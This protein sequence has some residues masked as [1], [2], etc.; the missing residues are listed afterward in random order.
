MLTNPLPKN[1][2]MNSRTIDPCCASGGNKNPLEATSVHGCINMMS[3]AKVVTRTKDYGLSQPYLGK[4]P[5]PHESPL[6]I[7][8]PM[9]NPEAPPRIPKGVLKHLR[10]NPNA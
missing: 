5:S 2:N 1:Q 6:R 3:A 9:D 8:K 10:H 7:E 4:E